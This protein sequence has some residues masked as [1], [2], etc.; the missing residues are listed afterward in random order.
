M[1]L[2]LTFLICFSAN[3]NLLCQTS[4][5]YLIK[6]W[7][8]VGSND[9]YNGSEVQ[10]VDTVKYKKTIKFSSDGFYYEKDT[11][12]N[13][14]GKWKCNLRCSR[15]GMN[16]LKSNDQTFEDRPVEEY[17]MEIFELSENSLIIGQQG[18]HGICKD[19]Y[20]PIRNQ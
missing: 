12:N 16:I 7:V 3:L 1:K 9:P 17:S 2:I 6:T 20:V 13:V 11:W 5:N 18:R 19:Y 4:E 15:I 10:K 8:Q 14:N